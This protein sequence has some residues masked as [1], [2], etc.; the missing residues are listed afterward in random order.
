MSFINE[1]EKE[2]LEE[3]KS[4]A[5]KLSKVQ[6][7]TGLMMYQSDIQR[8]YEDFV[9]LKK[10]QQF[11]DLPENM[12]VHTTHVNQTESS[13]KEINPTTPK[14]EKAPI[15]VLDFS[16]Q[17]DE[18]IQTKDTEEKIDYNFSIQ[19]EKKFKPLQIDL[20][21]QVAFINSLFK[22]DKVEYDD[23]IEGINT[24]NLTTSKTYMTHM[25]E[26]WGWGTK[27]QEFLERISIL[28][29]NRFE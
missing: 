19:S 4:L 21:D 2:V 29:Q 14:E 18:P 16:E 28:N 27:E 5:E 1:K 7:Y 12:N 9:F 8:F 26:E 11:R 23:F 10:L 13:N 22:G 25:A 6:S 17:Q 3:I 15:E 20:N 24:R